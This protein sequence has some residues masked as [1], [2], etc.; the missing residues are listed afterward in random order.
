MKP[1]EN[2]INKKSHIIFVVFWSLSVLGTIVYKYNLSI[3]T[4]DHTQF[5]W[6]PDFILL[7]IIL[8]WAFKRKYY[9]LP[10]SLI[11]LF[12][13]KSIGSFSV[14]VEYSEK[15]DLYKDVVKT[16]FGYTFIFF[17][18][19]F[20]RTFDAEKL[21][22][23]F[24]FFKILSLLAYGL[25]FIGA[26][27]SISFFKTYLGVRFGYSGFLYPSSYA[28]YFLII[29]VLIHYFYSTNIEKQTIVYLLLASIAGLLVGTKAVY[30]FL[31]LFWSIYFFKHKL[32]N[33]KISWAF[34]TITIISFVLFFDKIFSFL[35]EKFAV[36]FELFENNNLLTFVLSYRDISLKKA[37]AFIS[38]NWEFYNYIVGGVNRKELL[39]EMS[40]FDLILNFGLL[41]A[42]IF[43]LLYFFNIIKY[44]QRNTHIYLL[45]GSLLLITLLSGNFFDRLYLVY[46]LA[47]F[48]VI[49]SRNNQKFKSI[50]E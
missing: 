34:I 40:P 47:F 48:F 49:I 32:Y 5:T 35:Q 22:I 43:I 13:F 33:Y 36:L 2:V 14:L 44:I 6:I 7:S 15:L 28:S 30:L 17:V 46:P 21:K 25:I 26:L 42:I 31:F 50:P 29:S 45:L 4:F 16:T 18:F 8:I 10:L 3:R 9:F 1:F 37:I 41:G 27:F 23:T 39:V 19:A 12:I 24:I 38:N 11:A 20:L